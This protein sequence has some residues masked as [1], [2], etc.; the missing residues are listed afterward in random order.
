M[1]FWLS[2]KVV[3]LHLNN[4]T[5]KAYICNQGSTASTFLSRLACHIINLAKKHGIILLPPYIPI[6]LNME[7]DFLSQERFVSYW[8]LLPHTA[9][10]AFQLWC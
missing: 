6:H 8:P 1:A 3:A 10:A 7:A 5:A 9:Q 2:G 4:S